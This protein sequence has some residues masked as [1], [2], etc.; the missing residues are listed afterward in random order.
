MKTENESI[1]LLL[2][3]IKKLSING[4][5]LYLGCTQTPIGSHVI[6]KSVLKRL[7]PP[8]QSTVLMWDPKEDTLV[9]NA[10][11]GEDAERIYNKKSCA[12]GA[13]PAMKTRYTTGEKNFCVFNRSVF[14]RS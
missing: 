5:C 4:E 11:S 9:K 6:A 13:P 1:D 14:R 8:P 12:E 7:G 3:S 10:R 2:K